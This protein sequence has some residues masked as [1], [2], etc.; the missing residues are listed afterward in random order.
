MLQ[1]RVTPKAHAEKP[2]TGEGARRFGGRWNHIGT[3]VV[4][5]SGALSLAVLE[6]LVNLS[7]SD[8][9]D[10]LVSIQIQIPDDIPCDE[11]AVDDLPTNWRTFPAIEELKDIGT[12]WQHEGKTAILAVPSVVIPNERNY[13]INPAHRDSQRVE[14]L[15]VEPFALDPR[16]YRSRK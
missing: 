12:E 6:Y 9:P 15:S 10:D 2:L 5:T 14:I 1:W 4:Y 16:L 8:L 3:Q 7:I 13:L 11:V